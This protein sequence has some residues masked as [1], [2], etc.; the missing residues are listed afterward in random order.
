MSDSGPPIIIKKIKKGG[1]GHHGGSWKVA[2]ADFVTAMMALF[3]VLWVIG[4]SD[5]VKEAVSQYF[6]DPSLSPEEIAIKL[7]RSQQLKNE[8]KPMETVEIKADKE[9]EEPV[10]KMRSLA[11]KIKDALEKLHWEGELE[12]QIIIELTDEGLRVELLDFA[13]SPFFD[14][15]SASP[16]EHTKEALRAIGGQLV[17]ASNEVVLEGHTDA[18]PFHKGSYG[19]WEL[20]TDRANAAR[21]VLTSVGVKSHRISAVRGY[22]DN[23]LRRPESPFD[24]TNRRVSIVI[25]YD[26]E[27]RAR[28][29]HQEENHGKP[30]SGSKSHAEKPHSKKSHPEKPH[31]EDSHKKKKAHGDIAR[32]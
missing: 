32:H 21:R 12:G 22:A 3:I 31:G 25:L 19:N 27:V 9:D 7:S 30:S 14:S 28:K 17:G 6:I 16:K 24:P 11:N 26:E 18:H 13:N 2:Y 5:P 29:G 1:H 8:Q 23:R 4:Q 10:K 20:S 15:G